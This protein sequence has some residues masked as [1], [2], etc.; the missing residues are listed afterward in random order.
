M[1]N[2]NSNESFMRKIKNVKRITNAVLVIQKKGGWG[3]LKN[4]KKDEGA[5]GINHEDGGLGRTK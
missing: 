2:G 3:R 4:K 1:I 5:Y